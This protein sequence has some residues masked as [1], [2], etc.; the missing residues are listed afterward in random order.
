VGGRLPPKL[1]IRA[2]KAWVKWLHLGEYCYNTTHQMSIGMT[3]FIDLYSYD[4]ISFVDIFFGDSR[5][6][7]V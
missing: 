2:K 6:S 4:P 1:C 3:P 7:M 5:D